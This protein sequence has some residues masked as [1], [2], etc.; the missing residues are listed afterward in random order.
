MLCQKTT[1]M[2][3]Q[4]GHDLAAYKPDWIGRNYNVRRYACNP[5]YMKI[6]YPEAICKGTARSIRLA[7]PVPKSVFTAAYAVLLDVLVE[8]RKDAGLTQLELARRLGRPQPFISYIERGERRI[9][10]VEFYVIARALGC[11]PRAL[12]DRVITNLPDQVVI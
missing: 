7:V 10:V 2:K 4:L 12:F 3:R 9:D 11:D 1:R 8:A 5:G 6:I